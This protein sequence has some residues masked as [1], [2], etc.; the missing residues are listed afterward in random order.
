MKSSVLKQLDIDT[1]RNYLQTEPDIINQG[2]GTRAYEEAIVR[3][4]D[5]NPWTYENARTIL[6]ALINSYD[7]QP[8]VAYAA[9]YALC[10]YYRR[11]KH[12]SDFNELITEARAEFRAKISYA[13]LQLMCRKHMDPNDWTILEEAERLSEPDV[14]GY[15]YGVEHC[16]AEQVAAACE[17]DPTHASYFVAEYLDDA[18]ARV[19]DALKQSL[20]YPKFY[21][22]RAR[23]QNIKAIYADVEDREAYFKQSQNDIELAISKETDS[24]KQVDYQLIGLKMQSCYYESILSATIKKQETAISEKMQE[25]NVKSLEFLSFFSA[26]IGLLI[27]GTQ[28]MLGLSFAAGST[29][30]VVLTGCLITAFGT[31]GFVLYGTEKR[32]AANISIVIIGIALTVAAMLYGAYYAM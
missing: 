27:A 10:T 23:L 13:F 9:F 30:I 5:Q 7:E 11:H 17:K 29:L 21:V 19:N 1:V 18:L 4:I 15:N 22:T 8:E 12:K 32:L 6:K 31:I 28:I 16:F 20:G 25:G 14:M 26:I 2:D 3:L 24:A